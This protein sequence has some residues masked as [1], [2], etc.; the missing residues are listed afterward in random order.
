MGPHCRLG[1]GVRL[2]NCVLMEGVVV[3]DKVRTGARGVPAS[4]RDRAEIGPRLRAGR[5]RWVPPLS[6]PAGLP[7]L[8]LC[9]ISAG[10]RLH[11]GCLSARPQVHMS[12]CILC[13]G[14]EA[15]PHPPSLPAGT[16]PACRCSVRSRARRR[17]GRTGALWGQVHEGATLKDVQV[18]SNVSV[19]AG[20][21]VKS[22]ALTAEVDAEGSVVGSAEE[23]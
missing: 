22:E 21:N 20:A 7:S 12:N 5:R 3:H 19:E 2:T 4:G 1:A 17:R 10:P 13:R 8:R 18:G 15:S 14:A 16:H 11:L 6:R 9:L 23:D